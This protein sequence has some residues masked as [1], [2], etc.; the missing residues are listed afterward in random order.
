MTAAATG[1]GAGATGA[2][3]AMA[4]TTASRA[5]RDSSGSR[6][7][8]G[9]A[10]SVSVVPQPAA[11][12]RSAARDLG[13]AQPARLGDAPDVLG[14]DLEGGERR[15]RGRTG[16]V[17]AVHQRVQ[18][19]VGQAEAYVQIPAGSKVLDRVIGGFRAVLLVR[20][21]VKPSA[22]TASSRPSLSPK[23]R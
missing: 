9:V 18:R 17:P 11:W 14:E 6:R 16:A 5:V 19:R 23:S 13:D 15:G 10:M 7:S 3:V 12:T 2:S 8:S 20:Y 1:P 4:A 22:T 21:A